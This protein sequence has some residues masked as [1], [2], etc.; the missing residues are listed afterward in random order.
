VSALPFAPENGVNRHV[1]ISQPLPEYTEEARQARAEGIVVVQAIV[2]KDGTV[3]NCKIVKGLG[4]GLDEAAI[5]NIRNKWRFQPGT[6]G[7]NEPLNVQTTIETSFRL[8]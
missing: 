3:G 5:N 1:A 7:N 4:Y 6:N 8:Y 2:R